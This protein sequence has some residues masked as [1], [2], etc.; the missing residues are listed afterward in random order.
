VLRIELGYEAGPL[1][2]SDV[3]VFSPEEATE[4]VVPRESSGLFSRRTYYFGAADA[5]AKL[6]LDFSEARP[7]L[8]SG[9][10]CCESLHSRP[11]TSFRIV[12][13]QGIAVGMMP[14]PVN[15]PRGG[16]NSTKSTRARMREVVD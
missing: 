16:M 4:C 7:L 12:C 3:N 11:S 5:L 1:A 15:L 14:V 8:Q 6:G 2:P 9:G 10:G 13:H